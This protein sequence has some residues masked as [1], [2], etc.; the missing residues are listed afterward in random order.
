MAPKFS[1]L[2]AKNW[3]EMTEREFENQCKLENMTK[4]DVKT[5][6][7]PGK[8]QSSEIMIKLE[9]WVRENQGCQIRY[10]EIIDDKGTVACRGGGVFLLIGVKDN[11][12]WPTGKEPT[13]FYLKNPYRNNIRPFSVQINKLKQLYFGPFTPPVSFSLPGAISSV[14][15]SSSKS[16]PRSPPKSPRRS[17]RIARSSTPTQTRRIRG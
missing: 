2:G 5:L 16:P 13:F 9:K 6:Q 7:K 15:S 3:G 12:E 10:V 14:I 17:Q 8:Q 1:V 4:F 11:A